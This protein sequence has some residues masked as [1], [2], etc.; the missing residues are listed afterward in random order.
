MRGCA[1]GWSQITATW[2]RQQRFFHF[3][4]VCLPSTRDRFFETK[5]LPRVRPG[6][7]HS[8]VSSKLTRKIVR[9]KAEAS[10][11]A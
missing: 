7:K 3:A 8:D 5:T 11:S 1:V 9:P 10:R 6:N 4:T 2:V